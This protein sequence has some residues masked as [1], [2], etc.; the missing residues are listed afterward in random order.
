VKG[1]AVYL[2]YGGLASD[3][4]KVAPEAQKLVDSVEWTGS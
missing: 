1:E 2:D 4:D 3:F